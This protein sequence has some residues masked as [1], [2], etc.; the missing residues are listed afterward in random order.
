MRPNRFGGMMAW[1]V[2]SAFTQGG[3]AMAGGRVTCFRKGADRPDPRGA[4][5]PDSRA[6][7]DEKQ[8]HSLVCRHCGSRVTSREHAIEIDGQHAHAFFNPAGL[9]FEIGCF[10][11]APG[12]L[13]SGRPTADFAWF[14]GTLWRY[15]GCAACGTHLGWLFLPEHPDKLP[16]F[17]LILNRLAG[18]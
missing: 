11:D 18:G 7:T 1:M 4:P 9:L 2:E 16:F 3:P 12:C 10:S 8:E 13:V 5:A 6:E 17:G 15:A 14:D